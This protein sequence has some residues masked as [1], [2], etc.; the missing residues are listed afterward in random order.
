MSHLYILSYNVEIRLALNHEHKS[1][2]IV[3]L[4][5]MHRRTNTQIF[6]LLLLNVS[7]ITANEHNSIH[8]NILYIQILNHTDF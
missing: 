4:K 2:D 1:I 6:L 3:N 8:F 5:T 7:H